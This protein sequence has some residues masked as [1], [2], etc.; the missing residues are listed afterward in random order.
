M[1]KKGKVVLTLF[2]L[3]LF[4]LLSLLGA[5]A[6]YAYHPSKVKPF[7]ESAVSRTTG[8]QCTIDTLS[9]SFKPFAAVMRGLSL[10][11][12]GDS[13]GFELNVP[14]LR[15]EMALQGPF[16]RRRLVIKSLFVERPSF[17]LKKEVRLPE[18][19]GPSRP[20]S[21]F[22]K[23]VKRLIALFLFREVVFQAAG[24]DQGRAKGSLGPLTFDLTQI[25]A[26]LNAEHRIDLFCRGELNWPDKSLHLVAEAIH[27]S[28][29]GAVSIATPVLNGILELHEAHLQSPGAVVDKGALHAEVTYRHAERTLSF[30][31]MEAHL[32]GLQLHPVPNGAGQSLDLRLKASG[33]CHLQTMTIKAQPFDVTAEDLFHIKGDFQAGFQ[34]QARIR[35]GNLDG[36]LVPQRL[37]SFLPSPARGTGS[38]PKLSGTIWLRGDL[39]G[40]KEPEGWLWR[41]DLQSTLSGNRFAYETEDLRVKGDLTGEARVHGLI[42][43]L[44]VSLDLKGEEAVFAYRDLTVKPV[45]A[46]I[47]LSGK[48]PLYTVNELTFQVPLLRFKIGRVERT[49]KD[50]RVLAHRGTLNAAKLALQFPEIELNS[51]VLKNLRLSL[52]L[53]ADQL[54]LALKGKETGLAASAQELHILPDGWKSAATDRLRLDAA[55]KH[56]RNWSIRSE[57]D[58]EGLN[59]QNSSGTAAGQGIVLHGTLSSEG[60]LGDPHAASSIRFEMVGGEILFD[61]FY[62]NLGKYPFKATGDGDY[63][64]FRKELRIEDLTFGLN[65]ILGFRLKGEVGLGAEA[66]KVQALIQ[67][68]EVPVE[69]IFHHL[70]FEPFRM[71]K[72]FLNRLKLEGTVSARVELGAR[73]GK[74]EAKGH[75]FWRGG[76]LLDLDHGFSFHEIDLDLPFW[77]RNPAMKDRDETPP[78]SG[79]EGLQGHLTLGSM[80]L[81][82]LPAQPLRVPFQVTPNV[83][84]IPMPTTLRL[85]GGDIKLNPVIARFLFPKPP[86]VVTSLTA[87]DMDLTPL[88][89]R[90]WPRPVQGLAQVDLDP[91]RFGKNT[92]QAQ[93]KI[94]ASIFGGQ[95]TLSNPSLSGVFSAAPVFR[96]DITLEDLHLAELTKE[97]TFGRIEGILEGDIKNLEIAYGQPQAFDLRLET[98]KEP[99]VPQ[100]IS[101]RAVDNIAQIGGG[102]SPFTGL[103]EVFASFFKEFPYEK[104]GI[105][106]SLKNDMFRINGTIKEGGKEYLVKRSGFS[107]VNVVNQNPD[108]LISF[109]DMVKRIE[110]V[111]SSKS[112]P[113]VK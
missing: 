67:A 58:F 66:K 16:A 96:T 110:R 52:D 83:L 10:R 57:I 112:G 64:R 29:D 32:Q 71:Q 20:T 86:L 113:V 48:H 12:A 92:V 99:G 19:Q 49:I 45:A 34:R 54:S 82:L 31:P 80:T 79:P 105:H 21:F 74:W 37:L 46:Q 6:F 13:E 9:Y 3:V 70:L 103:A 69:P 88:L 91:V 55:L 44:E 60:R 53:S 89:S 50:V 109:K 26:E 87:H 78:F 59:F 39:E 2:L 7:I 77:Y 76:E 106:A 8:A 33:Q 90:I 27:V 25:R 41:C 61:Q 72:P 23:I 63:D 22:S 42:P 30:D 38:P 47:R 68:D 97:T 100:R 81:P 95:V 4:L 18:I 17:L 85:R 28:S 36:Y 107:G 56:G 84:S 102:R 104:I 108:N 43:D 62:V 73:D 11:P 111:T 35:A 40:S 98:R 51:S 5:I 75:I 15:A 1:R 101:V 94:K 65:H 93:G 14:E 24:L